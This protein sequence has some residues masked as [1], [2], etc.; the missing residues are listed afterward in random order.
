MPSNYFD[1]GTFII[2]PNKDN[3]RGLSPVSQILY[4]WLAAYSDRD[5]ESFPSRANLADDCGVAVKTIDRAL[6]ELISLGLVEKEYR[7]RGDGSQTSSLYRIIL[8]GGGTKTS[9]GK[10]E[11]VAPLTQP[12]NSTIYKESYDSLGKIT[13]NAHANVLDEPTKPTESATSDGSLT[14]YEDTSVNAEQSTSKSPRI[15]TK[16]ITGTKETHVP[17]SLTEIS[18]KTSQ[19]LKKSTKN[20]TKNVVLASAYALCKEKQIPIRNHNTFRAKIR[21]M[22]D[23]IGEDKA[24]IFIKWLTDSNYIDFIDTYKPNI[25]D[26]IGIWTRY[27]DIL[28]YV[29]RKNIN[30]VEEF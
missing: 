23:T 7:Y 6:R 29:Q 12:Y 14:N 19:S 16:I 22:L 21:E 27:Q 24:L 3:I 5:G 8:H 10:D 15:A 25:T 2:V 4:M 9:L 1:K 26:G 18:S 30:R 11:N 28:V 17:L 20:S 13:E